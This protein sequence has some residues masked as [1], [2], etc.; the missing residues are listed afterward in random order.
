[1][2]IKI[3]TT[4]NRHQF[5]TIINKP[6]ISIIIFLNASWCKPC[7]SFKQYLYNKIG[8]LKHFPQI[9]FFDIDIDNPENIDIYSF[10][11]SKKQV[12]GVPTLLYFTESI[13]SELCISGDNKR[14]LDNL[15]NKVIEQ[16]K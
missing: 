1:M 15:F 6:N 13:Y 7:K 3:Y 16:N 8:I 2:S 10:L 5:Q 14:G 4:L 9:L 12:T 11:K